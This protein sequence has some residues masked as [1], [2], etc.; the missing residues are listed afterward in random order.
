MHI[1]A[2]KSVLPSHAHTCLGARELSRASIV[3]LESS[4][5]QV[6]PSISVYLVLNFP[7]G[8]QTS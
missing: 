4:T 5:W 2:A 8:G 3:G 1:T 7:L 6:K